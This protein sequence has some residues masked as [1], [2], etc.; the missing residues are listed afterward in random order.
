MKKTSGFT[1]A[2]L[3]IVMVILVLLAGLGATGVLS[4][5]KYSEKKE[6]EQ[7]R[8]Y[9]ESAAN[10][11]LKLNPGLASKITASHADAFSYIKD[12]TELKTNSCPCGG[13]YTAVMQKDSNGKYYFTVTC[14]YH[15]DG[16]NDPTSWVDVVSELLSEQRKE[17]GKNYVSGST[18]QNKLMEEMKK[19]TGTAEYPSYVIDG[20]TFYLKPN[21]SLPK[22]AYAQDIIKKIKATNPDMA[23]KFDEPVIMLSE[24]GSKYNSSSRWKGTYV[25]C[26]ATESWYDCGKECM[27][28][29]WDAILPYVFDE[30]GNPKDDYKV[31]N[32]PDL[33]EE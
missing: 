11:E 33:V 32:M 13:Q 22:G 21:V 9:A 8:S 5:L 1:L 19:K 15:T 2:E 18:L 29:S 3:I 14:S 27:F 28:A 4:Y 23:K 26:P 17:T 30:N 16:I 20:K 7:S 24:Y 25:Y 12:G 6:C 10:A 31:S